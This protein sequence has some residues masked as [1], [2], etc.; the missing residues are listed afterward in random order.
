[1]SRSLCGKE[2][3]GQINRFPLNH[4]HVISSFKCYSSICI[5]LSVRDKSRRRVSSSM[6]ILLICYCA[7]TFTFSYFLLPYM[8]LI[9]THRFTDKK[10]TNETDY[11]ILITGTYRSLV[12]T[13]NFVILPGSLWCVVSTSQASPTDGALHNCY[14]KGP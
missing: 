4:S 13:Y 3:G 14:R 10:L 8:T 5:C 7:P 11:R 2:I 9:N 6:N 12:Y 1:M